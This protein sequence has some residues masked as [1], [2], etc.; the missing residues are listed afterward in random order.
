MAK[1]LKYQYVAKDENGDV[2]T[3][4]LIA[5]SEIVAARR[6]RALGLAPMTLAGGESAKSVNIGPPKKVKPK[7]LAVFNRQLVTMI[8]AGLP[9]TRSLAAISDQTDHPELKK[10]ATLVQGEV[11]SG[12][13]L[14]T[15]MSNYPKVFP[16]LMVAMVSAGEAG[17]GLGESLAQ[18]ATMYEKSAKLR[19][20]IVSALF[21]PVVVLA[22]AGIL[23]T[24]MLLF[25]VPIFAGVFESLGGELPL[26]T[27]V[28]MGVAAFLKVGLIP[29]IIA[30]IAGRIVWKRK[31]A[32]RPEVR[33][34]IDPIKLKIP[35]IG[36]FAQDIAL[37]RVNR[38][39]GS[40]LGTGIPLLGALE[41]AA[42][43]SGN[44]VYLDALEQTRE[45]VRTGRSLSDG[46]NRSDV[47]PPLMKQ[48]VSTGEE[49]GSLPDLLGKV[50]DFYDESVSTR[51]ETITSVIE[52][53]L[54]VFLGIIV[55]GMVI[56]LY[57]PMFSVYDNIG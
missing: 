33:S 56:S 2:R 51:S 15:A 57:L 34:R 43:T 53:L 54:L 28:L 49:S 42:N 25:I 7:H 14:S 40:L 32:E 18:V 4:T 50:A 6:L 30:A 21:Y 31:F 27:R 3:G 9:L 1:S 52:P 48:M 45:G 39:L 5:E 37:A 36:R 26:P 12:V 35:I 29:L 17:G 55:A 16:E 19:A 13:A 24:G 10:A 47:F 41:I 38:T 44:Y 20:K 8:D 23:I 22:L 11:E 46:I